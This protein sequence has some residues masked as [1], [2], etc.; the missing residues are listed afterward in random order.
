MKNKRKT[1]L[2][3]TFVILMIF[4][5]YGVINFTGLRSNLAAD[6][7]QQQIEALEIGMSRDEV[8]ASLGEP[9]S[10]EPFADGNAETNRT[11]M[12]YGRFILPLKSFPMLWV[13]L[14]DDHVVAVYAEIHYGIGADRSLDET[15]V[16]S[17]SVNDQWQ[18]AEFEMLFP[19][20]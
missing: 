18:T 17:L 16:Y 15:A 1:I 10:V 12:N 6:I 5:A 9:W 3:I 11:V 8:V 14:E 20:Q 4:I 7:T 2:T 13:H 19:V